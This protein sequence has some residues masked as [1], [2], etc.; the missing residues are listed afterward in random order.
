M[1]IIKDPD[2]K[3]PFWVINE[4]WE[5]ILPGL[6]RNPNNL[7]YARERIE[8]V[9]SDFLDLD[10][11]FNDKKRIVILSHGLEGTLTNTIC[12]AWQT[13]FSTMDGIHSHRIAEAVVRI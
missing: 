6:L 3:A 2:Y 8:T 13:N 11:V 7:N 1:P 12:G 5:T 10:F 9:D 4:H